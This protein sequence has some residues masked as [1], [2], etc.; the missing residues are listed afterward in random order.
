MHVTKLAMWRTCKASVTAGAG[1]ADGTAEVDRS[2]SAP[3]AIRVRGASP[4]LGEECLDEGRT[5]TERRGRAGSCQRLADE[6]GGELLE[7][8]AGSVGKF[9][10]GPLPGED[11]Q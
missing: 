8:T 5:G 4:G 11:G 1:P 7:V 2:R 9:T 3:V 10:Q 6:D